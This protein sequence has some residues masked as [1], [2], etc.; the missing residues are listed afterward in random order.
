MERAPAAAMRNRRALL[1]SLLA[2]PLAA[3]AG[4]DKDEGPT[5]F[6]DDNALGSDTVNDGAPDNSTLPDDNKAD[7]I[8]PATF[9]VGD[10][11]PVKSQG[12]RGVCSIFASTA[13][14]ENVYLHAGMPTPDFSEMYMQW[15]VKNL[16]G[17]FPH[18]DGSSS[19]AN[20]REVAVRGTVAEGEWAYESFPWS[21]ANDAEC[22]GGENLPTKCYTNGEPPPNVAMAR[23]FK[24][25]SSRWINTN[26]IKAHIFTKKTGVN[27]GMTFFYQAWNHRSSTLPVNAENW[28]QGYVSY[29]NAEDKTASLAH[30]AGHAIHLVGWDDNLEIC[31]R[32]G[33]GAD[34]ADPA[35]GCK[36]EK[37]FYIFKNSWGTA[38][39][40]IQHATGPGYGYISYKYINEYASAV[41]GEAP[42]LDLPREVCDD[43]ANADEDN[44]GDANCDDTDCAAACAPAASHTYTSTPAATIPDQSSV[45]STIAVADT[46]AVA[47]VKLSVDIS[48]T[49]QGDLKVTLT[50]GTKS[51]VVADRTGGSADNLVKTFDVAGITGD[52]AGDWTLKVEDTARLDTG[53]LNSWKLEVTT[54]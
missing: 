8:Y 24:L 5:P 40:G 31:M 30:R 19:D 28:R 45:S 39:F 11:S 51:V 1:A 35:G 42:P 32:D 29:P 25:A 13:L 50:K 16:G 17:A 47:T 33:A 36:K 22:T 9:Q 6:D 27:V 2:L 46:G 37:G 3:C 52:L 44:D 53:T 21:A 15:A 38:G 26:S 4:S 48:H 23:K 43:A 20:L 14:V 10:Q 34:I 54:N 7:A 12:S 49:Y 18:T 41:V